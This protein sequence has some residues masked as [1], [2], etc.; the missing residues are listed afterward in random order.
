[1]LAQATG[2]IILVRLRAPIVE[3]LCLDRRDWGYVHYVD[4]ANEKRGTGAVLVRT[5]EIAATP[6]APTLARRWLDDISGLRVLGQVAFDVRLLVTELVANSVR[7]AR[8]EESDLIAVMLELSSARVRVEVRDSGEGFAFP[9]RPH[10]LDI[11]GG[12]GLQIVAAIAHR[13]GIERGEP[14]AVWFEIDLERETAVG[15]RRSR[16][17]VRGLVL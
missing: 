5:L 11:E 9:A 3:S 2:T 10:K 4:S 8:L 12:R 17:C 1:M 7:H 13:W 16:E 6:E 15:T 14:I